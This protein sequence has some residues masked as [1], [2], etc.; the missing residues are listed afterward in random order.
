VLKGGQDHQGQEFTV[1]SCFLFSSILLPPM[2][3]QDR[4]RLAILELERIPRG[5]ATT[6][7]I[8]LAE[9]RELGRQLRRRLVDHWHRLDD[10]VERYKLA[11]GA[12]GTAGRRAI[13]S[14]R[15]SRS[16]TCCSTTSPTTR[17]SPNGPNG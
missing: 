14:G 6:P 9:L 11:L 17:R 7:T 15:C 1:R 12:S 5:I 8:D 4:N 13:S 10:L 2:L 3:A 16:P